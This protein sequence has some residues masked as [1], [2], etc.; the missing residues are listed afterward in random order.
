MSNQ[1]LEQ[2]LK[3]YKQGVYL[4]INWLQFLEDF[5][6]DHGAAMR[7]LVDNGIRFMFHPVLFKTPTGGFKRAINMETIILSKNLDPSKR[8]S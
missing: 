8:K 7:W 6:N 5:G 3:W 1:K 2:R 4:E